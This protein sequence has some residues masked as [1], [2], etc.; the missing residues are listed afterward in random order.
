MIGLH[1]SNVMGMDYKLE[2]IIDP[3][4]QGQLSMCQPFTS[5]FF[6]DFDVHYVTT[7]TYNDSIDF[8]R[9]ILPISG[10]QSPP[11]ASASAVGC[12]PDFSPRGGSEQTW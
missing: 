3:I 6:N 12:A 5:Y 2:P 11:G 9:H 1:Q 7:T 8:W 10:W 4:F